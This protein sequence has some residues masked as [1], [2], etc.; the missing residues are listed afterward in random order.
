MADN[1]PQFKGFQVLSRLGRGGMGTVWKALD[2]TLQRPV[3][4]KLLAADLASDP[5][6]VERFLREA[7]YLARLR[8]P[9]LVTIHDVVTVGPAPYLVMEYVEG[10]TLAAHL[11]K[12][13]LPWDQARAL[14]EPVLSA[15]AAVH[16]T[17]LIHRD[18]KPGNVLM[19]AE[20]RPKVVDFGLAKDAS[21]A[22]LTMEG[23]ILG[24]P[25]YMAPEQAKGD[26][27]SPASDVYSL[28]VMAYHMVSGRSPFQGP[29]T[30]A[31][32]RMVCQGE[33]APLSQ[34]APDLPP[35]ARA[36]IQK[37]MA[38]EPSARFR[39]AAEMLKALQDGDARS[40]S[41]RHPAAA[42]REEAASAVHGLSRPPNPLASPSRRWL[43]AGGIL[44]AVLLVAVLKWLP[45]AP[46]PQ[47]VLSLPAS[48]SRTEGGLKAI[49]PTADGGHEVVLRVGGEDRKI[50]VPP[51]AKAELNL[52]SGP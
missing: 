3:A 17:G 44:A 41:P 30:V 26:P 24:T 37:A 42:P 46:L 21:E 28:G 25:E 22:A 4:V 33:P 19:D 31:V 36:W 9:S 35:G 1:P 13:R 20:G 6:F 32:L 29:S 40:F 11:A 14:L 38:K 7:R 39:D 50:S 52:E 23:T 10:S 2:L 5:K 18:L 48:G 34:V 49:V 27:V 15:V 8:H 16:A 43:I 47:A 51:G 12:G 45:E